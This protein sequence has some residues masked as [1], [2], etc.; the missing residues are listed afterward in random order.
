MEAPKLIYGRYLTDMDIAQQRKVCVLGKRVYKTLFPQG[1]DPCGELVRLDSAYYRVIGV[2]RSGGNMNVNGSAD[3]SVVIPLAIMQRSFNMGDRL[4]LIA[5]TA[6]DGV[7]VSDI[8]PHIREVI[9]RG[10]DIDPTDEKGVRVFN[11]EVLFGLMD[12][13]F[14]GVDILIWLVGLGT[15]LAGAIGVSNIMMVTVKERTTEIGIRRAIGATPRMILR[16][17]IS[18]S[19]H[20]WHPLCRSD[21]A[22][23][24]NGLHGGRHP[25]DSFPGLLLGG[26]CCRSFACR[27]WRSCRFSPCGSCHE[28]QAS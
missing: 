19:I 14:D 15:L 8:T 5:F 21:T 6:R 10:H 11:T 3:E 28:Y 16:Q 25:E 9:A 27:P 4:E 23:D 24:A 13:L 18:E 7:A 1:G 20:V 22:R 12:T 26:D 17:I 2:D